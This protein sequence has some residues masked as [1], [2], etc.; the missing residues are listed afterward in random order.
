MND[1][2]FIGDKK[3]LVEKIWEVL[4]FSKIMSYV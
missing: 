2:E 4:Y 3:E 1:F